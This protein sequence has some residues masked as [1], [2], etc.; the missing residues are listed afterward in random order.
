MAT[1]TSSTPL[2]RDAATPVSSE[3]KEDA[4]VAKPV[5]GSEKEP[6]VSSPGQ[7]P[8]VNGDSE[9]SSSAAKDSAKSS[10]NQQAFSA[11]STV[12]KTS[13]PKATDDSAAQDTEMAI[14]GDKTSEATR[15]KPEE[16]SSGKEGAEAEAVAKDAGNAKSTAKTESDAMDVDD[17]IDRPDAS[18]STEH[19]DSTQNTSAMS[20]GPVETSADS[21]QPADLSKLE[22][23]A[24]QEDGVSSTQATDADVPMVDSSTAQA[25]VPREREDDN[26]DEPAA[27][28]AKTDDGIEEPVAD[29]LV[30]AT[31]SE[32]LTPVAQVT[33]DA[34]SK[35]IPDDAPITLF[36]NRKVREVLGNVKKTKNGH[37]FRRSVSDL[38]PALWDDYM[39]K[40]DTPID[41]SAM[42]A[43]LREGKYDNYGQLKADL[44]LLFENAVQFNGEMHD[45]TRAAAH[46]REYVL[47]RLPAILQEAEPVKLE[48]GK[49]QPTRHTE[50]RAA[51]QQPR[52]QSQAGASVTS[53]KTKTDPSALPTPTSASTTFAIPPSGIPQ[54]R[55][56]STRDD[57]NRPKRPIHPPKN[58]DPD[59][60]NKGTRKKLE[61]EQQFIEHVLKE[62]KKPQHSFNQWFLVAVDPV[63]LQI[64]NYFNVIKKPMDLETMANKNLDG[65]YK[66]VKDLEKDMKQI[67][68]NSEM[69]NGLES[70]VT[71]AAR[72]TENVMKEAIAGKDKWLE[73][74]FGSKSSRVSAA[75][76]VRTDTDSEDESE[77][78]DEEGD[79]EAV[80]SLQK[81]LGEEEAKV[82]ALM[83]S[84]NTDILNLEISQTI[85]TTLQRKIVEERANS[86]GAKKAKSK[87]KGGA[88]K[89][90]AKPTGSAAGGGSKKSGQQPSSQVKKPAGGTKKSAAP[91]KRTV[92]ALEKAVIA[93][94]INE[95]DG[96]TLIKAVE[97]IKKDT[98]QTENDDG[99]MELDIDSLS[100][101]ALG[102]LFDLIHKAHPNIRQALSQKEEYRKS[103]PDPPETTK[104]SKSKKNKPMNKHEQERKIQELRELK[105]KLQRTGSASQEPVAGEA[106]EPV[107]GET[108]DESDSEE[109]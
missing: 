22:I 28:R 90:K 27:K 9:A 18:S 65:E 39:T 61:P 2:E 37:N 102:K 26:M 63:A 56:D 64:P 17:P 19:V 77:G 6:G 66:T 51:T 40:I 12:A 108:S 3:S 93:E 69:F 68:T 54:I 79:S 62:V 43:K 41:I 33:S 86:S 85:I 59:Y 73:N 42:E 71:A 7:S 13:S 107:A 105:A 24:T 67:V 32:P 81:R 29:S 94:G 48:K 15:S 47:Q 91:K 49:A 4:P 98:H 57:S 10:L 16:V 5:N 11:N 83:K 99:E 8:A 52:R 1:E 97:I 92:G 23:Q 45:V 25:K 50:P 46:V 72:L 53:P 14:D 34:M 100:E 80:R 96:Q 87:K 60:G 104:P 109:E 20:D 103:A 30:V 88:T 36:Q 38:W 82:R 101:D 35:A 78:E 31:N 75:S 44:K 106:E 21:N 95:L 70:D 58:R 76:P 84:K 55:R 89:S 74:K